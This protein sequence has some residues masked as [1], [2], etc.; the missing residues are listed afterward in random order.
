MPLHKNLPEFTVNL[1]ETIDAYSPLFATEFFEVY[2]D[3]ENQS[4]PGILKIRPTV[5]SGI[6]KFTDMTFEK[7]VEFNQLQRLC[8][9]LLMQTFHAKSSGAYKEE[10]VLINA[11]SRDIA[12]SKD[13]PAAGQ[14]IQT[15]FEQVII[16]RFG[17]NQRILISP[18]MDVTLTT[19]PNVDG[20]K[21]GF[22]FTDPS[23]GKPFKYTEVKEPSEALYQGI[24]NLL[25]S[26]LKELRL[27]KFLDQI[28][29]LQKESS[30]FNCKKPEDH[31]EDA[32]LM[33]IAVELDGE[34][35]LFNS[36]IDARSQEKK[37]RGYITPVAH[38]NALRYTPDTSAAITYLLANAYERAVKSVFNLSFH[39]VDRAVL[40]N[41]FTADDKGPHV[42][43]HMVPRP[44]NDKEDNYKFPYAMD[45]KK[46]KGLTSDPVAKKAIVNAFCLAL[47]EEISKEPGLQNAKISYRFLATEH[48]PKSL[49]L[50][51]P[52]S[53]PG[54]VFAVKAT[55]V[56]EPT[57]TATLVKR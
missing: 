55:P 42:H 51:N 8:E 22:S 23:P 18:T 50:V 53:V 46:Y 57:A 1:N 30:C 15:R 49:A 25:R 32:A 54:T 20:D 13:M 3:S 21:N 43:L 19:D 40:M 56:E 7:L 47:Q 26:N 41:L 27:P 37:G 36:A 24:F 34:E 5:D 2:L 17:N 29:N 14:G 9:I 48:T 33:Q 52:A 11:Y 16:P 28:G 31:P 45:S 12:L 38:V 35:Y 6:T 39:T 44:V 10:E 4:V